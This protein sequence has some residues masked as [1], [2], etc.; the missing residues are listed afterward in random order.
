MFDEE[1]FDL[2]FMFVLD[3]LKNVIESNNISQG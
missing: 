1:F 2:D 3:E